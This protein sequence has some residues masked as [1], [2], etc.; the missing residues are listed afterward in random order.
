MMKLRQPRIPV[1]ST[2]TG[3][4]VTTTEEA[5]S[6]IAQGTCAQVSFYSARQLFRCLA[7]I[8]QQHELF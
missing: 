1:Y 4:A 5:A 7:M 3:E 2:V 8:R 6:C